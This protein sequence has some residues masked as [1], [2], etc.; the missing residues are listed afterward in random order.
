L[1]WLLAASSFIAQAAAVA[2]GQTEDQKTRRWAM[3]LGVSGLLGLLGWF[4][5]Y[6]FFAVNVANTLQ[7]MGIHSPLP[8]LQVTLP[9]GIS[10]YTFM[11]ISYVVDVYRRQLQPAPWLD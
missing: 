10:F 6:G 5:Y 7:S 11:G 8:L 3:G 2:V 4:K 1:V 9:V